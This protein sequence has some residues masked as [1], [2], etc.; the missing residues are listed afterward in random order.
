M[1]LASCCLE[2]TLPAQD[3]AAC[4]QEPAQVPQGEECCACVFT[5]A[6]STHHQAKYIP[7]QP[8]S[9]PTHHTTFSHPHPLAELLGRH[10]PLLLPY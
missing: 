4:M 10:A 6:T 7:S 9:A 5:E 3:H 2:V 8:V 1:V